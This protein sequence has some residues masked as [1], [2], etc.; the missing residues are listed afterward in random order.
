MSQP[1]ETWTVQFNN[2]SQ[3]LYNRSGAS[4]NIAIIVEVL[5]FVSVS[6][7]QVTSKAT[8]EDTLVNRLRRL[9]E[10]KEKRQKIITL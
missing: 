5:T 8:Q 2:Q 9:L 4:V 1:C 10:E 6:D 7:R 3:S